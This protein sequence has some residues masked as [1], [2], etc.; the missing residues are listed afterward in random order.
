[1]VLLVLISACGS[2][3][4]GSEE[5]GKGSPTIPGAGEAQDPAGDA[6]GR[7]SSGGNLPSQAEGVAPAPGSPGS[8]GS[9]GE[10]GVVRV[11]GREDRPGGG[12]GPEAP[13]AT[14]PGPDGNE[15]ELRV[16]DSEQR[17]CGRLDVGRPHRGSTG[18]SEC[19]WDPRIDQ[20][21]TKGGPPPMHR[22]AYGPVMAEATRVVLVQRNA[23]E[24]EA[25]IVHRSPD[26]VGYY[27][28]FP[29]LNEPLEKAQAFNA[30]GRLLAEYINSKEEEDFLANWDPFPD[31]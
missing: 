9:P 25:P 24:V 31:D 11:D 18:T 22:S 4:P 10:E 21:F 5:T 12:T 1:M 20:H 28:G 2:P 16:W 26:G 23:E 8:S 15:W 27:V 6:A 3:S 14:G 30:E 7:A 17:K 13:S 19:G 29:A